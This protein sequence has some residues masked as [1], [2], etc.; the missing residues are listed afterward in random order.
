MF[1]RVK[2][3]SRCTIHNTCSL[4]NAFWEIPRLNKRIPLYNNNQ[5]ENVEQVELDKHFKRS[6][7]VNQA[8]IGFVR[9]RGK[10]K[11]K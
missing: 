3:N 7:S 8:W 6:E 10:K 11:I 4:E 1:E 9:E 5:N 2:V